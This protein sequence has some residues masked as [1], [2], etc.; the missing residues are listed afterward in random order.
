[1]KVTIDQLKG[2]I[3]QQLQEGGSMAEYGKI[4]AEDGNPPSKIGRGDPAYMEAYNA[5]LVARGEE[6]LSIEK[7]DQ[8]YLDALRGGNLEEAGGGMTVDDFADHIFDEASNTPYGSN[9]EDDGSLMLDYRGAVKVVIKK[10]EQGAYAEIAG[11]ATDYKPEQIRDPAEAVDIIDASVEGRGRA[12]KTNAGDPSKAG[13]GGALQEKG[14]NSMRVTIDQLKGFIRQQL[15]E[16]GDHETQAA[17]GMVS[18][19]HSSDPE[20]DQ[21]EDIALTVIE[22]GGQLMQI[23]TALKDQAFDARVMSGVLVIGDDYF[24]GKPDKFDI[25]PDEEFREIGPYVLGHSSSQDPMQEKL[26]DEDRKF[27]KSV[28]DKGK[29][30]NL[31]GD[32]GPLPGME[33]PFQFKSGAVLYYDPKEGA[34][35]DRGKDMYIDRDEAAALTMENETV[36]PSRTIKISL[37]TIRDMVRSQMQEGAASM[38]EKGDQVNDIRN[39]KAYKVTEVRADGAVMVVG[40]DGEPAI[41]KADHLKKVEGAPKIDEGDEDVSWQKEVYQD[42]GA[43]DDLL[44]AINALKNEFGMTAEEMAEFI[45]NPPVQDIKEY[46]DYNRDALQPRSDY[47]GRPDA[48]QKEAN[49]KAYA[50]CHEMGKKGMSVHEAR[51]KVPHTEWQACM[52]GHQDGANEFRQGLKESRLSKILAEAKRILSENKFKGENK[53]GDHPLFKGMYAGNGVSRAWFTDLPSIMELVQQNRGQSEVLDVAARIAEGDKTLPPYYPFKFDLMVADELK[54]IGMD[55]VDPADADKFD[56]RKNS[57]DF[58]YNPPGW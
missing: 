31:K 50:L 37:N 17:G 18:S 56:Y 39:D 19:S 38:F 16:Y 46:G 51:K 47:G 35:Y 14:V 29:V 3:R 6:P 11:A 33:G 25:S 20:M 13:L 32:M 7:P 24:I 45:S 4:D 26:S 36:A 10:D 34:Y 42:G 2:L 44:Q 8:R 21:V 15:E 54:K 43:L 28:M 57:E 53:Q 52:A 30:P 40:E 27:H 41:I 5:V 58:E 48:E 22:Q 49:E 12:R 9:N 55:S 1:M 23:A